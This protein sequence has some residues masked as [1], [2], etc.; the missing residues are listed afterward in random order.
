MTGPEHPS[1]YPDDYYPAYHVYPPVAHNYYYPPT[2][3][4]TQLYP[5][6]PQP[7]PA[8]AAPGKRRRLW[9]GMAIGVTA[10]AVITVGVVALTSSSDEPKASSPQ[11]VTSVT[12]TKTESQ[13]FQEWWVKVRD[14]WQRLV[15]SQDG[16]KAAAANSDLNALHISCAAMERASTEVRN[17]LPAPHKELDKELAMATSAYI[18]AG[19]S[20]QRLSPASNT[21]EVDAV[22]NFMKIGNEHVQVATVILGTL[23]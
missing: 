17:L 18:N 2:E 19:Q 1:E 11:A 14:P 20:C 16:I 8:P 7:A 5:G 22:V 12:P 9:S 23:K 6:L 15:N 10:A 21:A 3:A 13:L 4:T